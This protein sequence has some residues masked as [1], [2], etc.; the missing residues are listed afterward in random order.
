MDLE[1]SFM[2]FFIAFEAK[3][4]DFWSNIETFYHLTTSSAIVGIVMHIL[5]SFPKEYEMKLTSKNIFDSAPIVGNPFK[6]VIRGILCWS[7]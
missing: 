2:G 4:N 1:T 7:R 3:I 5:T 6:A